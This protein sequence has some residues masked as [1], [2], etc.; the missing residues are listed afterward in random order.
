MHL[1]I[2]CN[3]VCA[4]E[5]V[6][7]C[8][9]SV[10]LADDRLFELLHPACQGLQLQDM[11]ARGLPSH[12]GHALGIIEDQQRIHRVCLRPLHAGLRIIVHRFG[13]DDHDVRAAMMMQGQSHL[14]AIKPGGFEAD[15]DR[16]SALGEPLQQTLVCLGIVVKG[17]LLDGLPST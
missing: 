17:R 8:V 10:A 3:E 11:L 16:P 7:L 14:Q 4:A 13:I 9:G 1:N 15:T 6:A 12:K 2:A 5:G